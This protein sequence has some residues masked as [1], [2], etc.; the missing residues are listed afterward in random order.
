MKNNI[1]FTT[2]TQVIND[3]KQ[4]KTTLQ[5]IYDNKN[6]KKTIKLHVKS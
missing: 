3:H 5:H 1:L 6:L 2:K 4:H